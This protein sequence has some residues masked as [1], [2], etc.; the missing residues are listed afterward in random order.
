MDA[1]Y[2]DTNHSSPP[3]NG[4]SPPPKPRGMADKTYRNARRKRIH[5]FNFELDDARHEQLQAVADSRAISM[6]ATLR[7]L[8]ST[9]YAMTAQ[10]H[11]MCVN[12]RDCF[13]PHMH[14]PSQSPIPNKDSSP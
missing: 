10:G 11:P 12:G 8:I 9:A 7:Q 6:G 3:P 2:D 13:M 4:D 5:P 1:K 14:P